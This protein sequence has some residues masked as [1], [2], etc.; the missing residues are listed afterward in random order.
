[1]E[2]KELEK[3]VIRLWKK[4]KASEHDY[5]KIRKYCNKFFPALDALNKMADKEDMKYDTEYDEDD[6]E[7]FVKLEYKD[8]IIDDY[9]KLDIRE[10]TLAYWR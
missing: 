2:R 3:Y 9:W 8:I 4:V 10:E 1:M 7:R 6:N 5:C